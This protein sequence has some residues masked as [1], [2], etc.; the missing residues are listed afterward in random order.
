MGRQITQKTAFALILLSSAA[1]AIPFP[2][3]QNDV[4]M[5]VQSMSQKFTGNLLCLAAGA[6][7]PFLVGL[8]AWGGFI[9]LMGADDPNQ[10]LMGKR[11]V[12]DAVIGAALIQ[13]LLL[14]ANALIPGLTLSFTGC[15]STPGL[16]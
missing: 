13:G 2:N 15:L 3:N 12:K 1:T 9:W 7:V 16:F 5:W 6:A 10:R 4:W 14:F 8:I 11:I